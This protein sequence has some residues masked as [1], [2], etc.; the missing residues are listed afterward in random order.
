MVVTRYS[1]FCIV[2]TTTIIWIFFDLLMFYALDVELEGAMSGR[3]SAVGIARRNVPVHAHLKNRV[4]DIAIVN[5]HEN[6]EFHFEEPSAVEKIT[7]LVVVD[8]KLATRV[9]KFQPLAIKRGVKIMD[10]KPVLRVQTLIAD[11]SAADAVRDTGELHIKPDY[12]ERKLK[13]DEIPVVMSLVSCGSHLCR[14][15]VNFLLISS[16]AS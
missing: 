13:E 4:A 16:T 2:S 6:A 8:E 5:R 1:V 9:V 15:T 12:A 10:E 11:R 3:Q 7:S 14:F